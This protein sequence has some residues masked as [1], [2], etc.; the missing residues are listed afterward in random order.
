MRPPLKPVAARIRL[1]CR[2]VV[3][4]PDVVDDNVARIT[5]MK[6]KGMINWISLFMI[7]P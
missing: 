4:C 5:R 6:A 7:S 2:L 3:G 1:A